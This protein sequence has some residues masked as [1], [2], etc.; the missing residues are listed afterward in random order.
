M[1]EELG[2]SASMGL[3]AMTAERPLLLL[4]TGAPGAGKTTFYENKLRESFPILLK[5]SS[6]PLEQVEVERQRKELLNSHQSFVFQSSVAD[7]SLLKEARS[8]GYE[9]KAIFIGTEH[10]DLNVARILSRVSRGGLFAPIAALQ[11]EYEN[12]LRQL[13]ALAKAADELV[14]LDNTAE[15]RSPRVIAQFAE[16]Q[17]VK[18][19]R[20]L[21]Q[22]AQKTFGKEFGKS[23]DQNQRQLRIRLR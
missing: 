10:P 19:A 20:S 17:V 11:E 16:G 14:L 21:P 12:G 23:L 9:V 8:H 22:W 2:S 13:N 18:M 15:G 6:S 5:S 4:V 1:A 3:S 7:L